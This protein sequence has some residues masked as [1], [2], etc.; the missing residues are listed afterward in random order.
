MAARAIAQGTDAALYGYE[1]S[2]S[3][4]LNYHAAALRARA[5]MA[6]FPFWRMQARQGMRNESIRAEIEGPITQNTDI[7]FCWH[8]SV[9]HSDH[10]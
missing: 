2:A 10:R 8:R 4:R 1:A 9:S 3:R 6:G 7:G 5:A